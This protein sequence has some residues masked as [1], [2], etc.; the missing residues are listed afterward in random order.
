VRGVDRSL[1]ESAGPHRAQRAAAD[2]VGHRLAESDLAAV[3]TF[4]INRGF[5]LVA[6]FTEDRALLVHAVETLGI[7][8]LTRISDPLALAADLSATDVAT[9]G[10]N[11][12]QLNSQAI[13]GDVLAVLARRMRA[14]EEESYRGNVMS[15]ISS[16]EDLAR[17]L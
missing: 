2:S 5:H 17:G 4:D 13:L 10:V 15:L 8:S 9:P 16:F 7:P 3:A 1:A 14:A 11:R 6:N 12:A